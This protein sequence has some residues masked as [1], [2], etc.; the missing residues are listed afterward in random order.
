M[1][2]FGRLSHEGGCVVAPHSSAYAVFRARASSVLRGAGGAPIR[3]PPREAALRPKDR[4]VTPAFQT[5][6]RPLALHKIHWQV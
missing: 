1:G 2:R 6:R 4:V 5:D 3:G